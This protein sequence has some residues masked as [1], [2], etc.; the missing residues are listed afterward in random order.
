MFRFLINFKKSKYDITKVRDLF[1][2]I[3]LLRSNKTYKFNY[4]RHF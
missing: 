2:A 4:E 3:Y 1:E